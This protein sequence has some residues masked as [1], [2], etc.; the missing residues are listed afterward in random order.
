MKKIYILTEEKLEKMIDEKVKIREKQMN[1]KLQK[2]VM[3]KEMNLANLQSQ[4]NPHFLYNALEGIRGQA[5]VD[6]VPVIEKISQALASY[7]RYN[8]SSKSDIVT[9]KEELNNVQ[10]YLSIQQ[11]R[12]NNRFEV[13]ICYENEDEDVFE[14]LMPKLTLQPILENAISHGMESAK[15]QARIEIRIVK[16]KKHVSIT[17]SDNGKGISESGLKDLNERI[18]NY[19]IMRNTEGKHIGIA[20]P[21]IDRRIKLMYGDDYGIHISSVLGMGTDVEV[22]LPFCDNYEQVK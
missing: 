6:N 17:I 20:M 16:T 9:L 2:K 18:K 11:F 21:N 3:E 4:I 13:E 1:L 14:T 12:F 15:K 8:I 22:Y 10:N 5:I 19:N 7:F